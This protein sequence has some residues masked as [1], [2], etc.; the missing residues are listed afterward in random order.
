MNLASHSYWE[1][2]YADKSF[3]AIDANNPIARLIFKYFPPLNEKDWG[4]QSVFEIGCFPGNFLPLFGSLGYEL[5]GLDQASRT[6]T[7]LKEW[8]E[9]SHFKVGQLIRADF[10]SFTSSRRYELV[11]S[12]GFIE[13]FSETKEIILAHDRL[14]SAGGRLIITA[15]NFRGRWQKIFHSYFDQEN[16]RRHNIAA[17]DP[18]LW[19]KFVADLGYEIEYC[20]CFGGF[21]FWTEKERR[22]WLKKIILLLLMKI[23]YFLRNCPW[24]NSPHY[25]PFCALIAKKIDRENMG[26]K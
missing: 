16:Y 17:M 14:L 9:K 20:G 4:R 23:F 2:M 25:S 7:E 8:L 6:D 10:K 15:P 3:A 13:H 19:A 1:K 24:P 5:N 11:C 26:K 12:F 22:H 18:Y 21:D